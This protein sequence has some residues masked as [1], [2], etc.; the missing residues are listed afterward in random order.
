MIHCESSNGVYVNWLY[1]DLQCWT[2]VHII[3]ATIAILTSILFTV[4]C[5]V[6]SL[7]YYDS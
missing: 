4:I 5:T 1:A 3:H 6:V 7:T 2:G